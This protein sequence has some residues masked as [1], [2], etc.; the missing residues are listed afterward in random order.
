MK[1]D[2][3]TAIKMV[4]KGYLENEAIADAVYGTYTGSGLKID[5][6]PEIIPLDMVDIP[7]MLTDYQTKMTINGAEQTVTVKNKL[8]PGDRVAAIQKYRGQK[9]LIVDRL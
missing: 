7:K 1:V 8:I 2:V 5:G 4:I 9:Y 3:V 6:K